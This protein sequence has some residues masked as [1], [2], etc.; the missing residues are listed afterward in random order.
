[1]R[2]YISVRWKIILPMAAILFL[3]IT[4]LN[5]Y[6]SYQQKERLLDLTEHQLLDIANGYMDSM[7]ALMF[8]GAM[9]SREILRDKISQ[10]HF[11]SRLWTYTW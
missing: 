3:I 5:L 6:S 7:N 8:T 11:L 1:M 2:Q 10:R 4:A 9:A